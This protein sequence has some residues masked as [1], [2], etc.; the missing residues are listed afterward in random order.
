MPILT[1]QPLQYG[2]RL[3]VLGRWQP[4]LRSE[5][6]M[7]D[8]WNEE[9]TAKLT[10][11]LQDSCTGAAILSQCGSYRG[12]DHECRGCRRHSGD[13]GHV[14]GEQTEDSYKI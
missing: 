9:T 14:E 6:A 5:E 2:M 12:W 11:Q 8:L 3:M 7:Y 10:K 1:S 13:S 4:I